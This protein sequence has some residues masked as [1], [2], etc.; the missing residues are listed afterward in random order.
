MSEDTK[1]TSVAFSNVKPRFLAPKNA[2]IVPI[3]NLAQKTAMAESGRDLSQAKKMTHAEHLAYVEAKKAEV[4]AEKKA[5]KAQAKGEAKAQGDTTP[6]PKAKEA[7]PKAETVLFRSTMYGTDGHQIPH[8]YELKGSGNDDGMS[9][10]ACVARILSAL[11]END[12]NACARIERGVFLVLYFSG[13]D[14]E[15]TEIEWYFTEDKAEERGVEA[16]NE[17]GAKRFTVSKVIQKREV[18]L[19]SKMPVRD[20]LVKSRNKSVNRT[21]KTKPGWKMRAKQDHCH[22]SHG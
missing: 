20:Q 6:G 7:K 10:S 14:G 16:C 1:D 8:N 9:P 17:D 11:V 22:F 15:Y 19:R 3:V 5:R 21:R 12:R 2:Q 4:K 18:L 13:P